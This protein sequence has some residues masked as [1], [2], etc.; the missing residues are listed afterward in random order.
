MTRH[1]IE[2]EHKRCLS[3]D[4]A[5]RVLGVG[6]QLV[7]ARIRSGDIHIIRWGTRILIPKASLEKDLE[8]AIGEA[9]NANR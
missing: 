8:R 2:F 7:R 9:S 3:I 6:E 4:E 1:T 5:A